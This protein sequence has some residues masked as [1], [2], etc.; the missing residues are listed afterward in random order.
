MV[1]TAVL[2]QVLTGQGPWR[3]NALLLAMGGSLAEA[4]YA[5]AVA[6]VLPHSTALWLKEIP[7]LLPSISIGVGIYVWYIGHTLKIPNTDVQSESTDSPNREY[8][9]LLRGIGLGIA[10]V[11]LLV[12]WTGMWQLL[13]L[14]IPTIESSSQWLPTWPDVLSF[15]IGAATGAFALLYALIYWLGKKREQVSIEPN[16]RLVAQ[17]RLALKAL[18]IA[19]GLYALVSAWLV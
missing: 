2:H 5:W 3:K 1:N 13:L 8:N 4:I 12:F 18:G 14:Y 11:Q 16:N 15:G 7:F 10:N 19:M 6:W 17:V 9:H